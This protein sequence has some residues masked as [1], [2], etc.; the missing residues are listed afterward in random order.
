M[1]K[2]L[3]LLLMNRQKSQFNLAAGANAVE[4][5]VYPKRSYSLVQDMGVHMLATF[6]LTEVDV[7]DAD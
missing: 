4:C 5:T 7:I 6:R 1:V 3:D 2:M